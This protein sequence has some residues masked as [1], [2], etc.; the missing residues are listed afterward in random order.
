VQNTANGTPQLQSYGL[1]EKQYQGKMV[2]DT[3][4]AADKIYTKT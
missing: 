2:G 1:G 3:V 4:E